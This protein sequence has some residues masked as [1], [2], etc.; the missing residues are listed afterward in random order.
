M[1]KDV[2]ATD[3]TWESL[4]FP[5][6][7]SQTLLSLSD[8]LFPP[9]ELWHWGPENYLFAREIIVRCCCVGLPLIHIGLQLKGEK[10]G[11]KMDKK[12]GRGMMRRWKNCC[13]F[14]RLATDPVETR[15]IL[16]FFP[17]PFYS[18]ESLHWN[19]KLAPFPAPVWWL[20]NVRLNVSE[21]LCVKEKVRL[22][23]FPLCA[24]FFHQKTRRR[25]DGKWR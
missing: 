9:S 20:R 21:C 19:Q 24:L 5:S 12:R 25:R 1:R 11:E 10:K 4:F 16:R 13:C 17:L 18:C 22:F 23:L 8:T 7:T 3:K 15:S 14:L 6:G 2:S